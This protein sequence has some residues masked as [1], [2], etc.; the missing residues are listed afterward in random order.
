MGKCP[1]CKA[2]HVDK[3]DEERI[4][5]LMKRVEANDAEAMC[6]L[7]NQ[8]IH[9]LQGLLQD[10]EKALELWKKA[11]EL[12]SSQAHFQL[13]VIYYEKGDLKKAKFHTEA[14]AMAGGEVARSNLGI[15]EGKSGNM[16]RAVKHLRI[17]ASAGHYH[18]MRAL[19]VAFRRG[20]I[21]RETIDSTLTAYNNSC[22]EMRSDA[23]DAYIRM[24]QETLT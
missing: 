2:D 11:A 4:K 1:F 7:G 13:G 21:S 8:Y 19:L 15:M 22:F 16:E 3:T 20:H 17:A 23:R 6:Q 5:E 10:Q 14:A 18:A 12:G 24:K 9:G